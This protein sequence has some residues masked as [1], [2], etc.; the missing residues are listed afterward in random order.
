MEVTAV[1]IVIIKYILEKDVSDAQDNDNKIRRCF[2][3]YCKFHPVAG[4]ED[5]KGVEV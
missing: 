2:V 5:E 3:C 4:H 1:R